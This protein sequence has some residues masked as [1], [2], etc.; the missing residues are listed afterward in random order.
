MLLS[1]ATNIYLH[2]LRTLVFRLCDVTSVIKIP[3]EILSCRTLAP[4]TRR[5]LQS[6][7]YS[8]KGW[9][10]AAQSLFDEEILGRTVPSSHVQ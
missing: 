8:C 6:I 2:V 9:Q 7:V 3:G 10:P 5:E 1:Q 4:P